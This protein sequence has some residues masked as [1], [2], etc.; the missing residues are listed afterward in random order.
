MKKKIDNK[1]KTSDNCS[2]AEHSKINIIYSQEFKYIVV[3]CYIC[4][5]TLNEKE[6]KIIFEKLFEN[7]KNNK[8]AILPF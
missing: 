5:E 4:E 2:F 6:V 8:T 3:N 1:V 7:L